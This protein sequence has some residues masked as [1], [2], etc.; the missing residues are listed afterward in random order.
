MLAEALLVR[1]GNNRE[2]LRCLNSFLDTVQQGRTVQ[3]ETTYVEDAAFENKPKT[4]HT[5]TR[6][7]EPKSM[8]LIQV[9]HPEAESPNHPQDCR[10]EVNGPPDLLNLVP[11]LEGRKLA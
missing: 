9:S 6:R 11:G 7:P 3:N 1:L 10:L 5:T 8:N 4:A 2:S